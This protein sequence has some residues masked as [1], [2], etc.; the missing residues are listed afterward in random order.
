[1]RAVQIFAQLSSR[2]AGNMTAV[3]VCRFASVSGVGLCALELY[4]T[5]EG[6]QCRPIAR[7]ARILAYLPFTLA[8]SLCSLSAFLYRF[9]PALAALPAMQ[10]LVCGYFVLWNGS[11][12]LQSSERKSLSATLHGMMVFCSLTPTA[13]W[14]VSSYTMGRTFAELASPMG[15]IFSR[16]GGLAAGG[17][18][19]MLFSSYLAERLSPAVWAV[20]TD[21]SG[22]VGPEDICAAAKEYY[23]I[24]VPLGMATAMLQMGKGMLGSFHGDQTSPAPVFSPEEE[25]GK[26]AEQ[27]AS[28]STERRS[29]PPAPASS[30]T[31]QAPTSQSRQ[32][33]KKTSEQLIEIM[34]SDA[35]ITP[36]E[37]RECVLA[38]RA[39]RREM[40]GDGMGAV[41]Q[42]GKETDGGAEGFDGSP[43]PEG[44]EGLLQ[45]GMVGLNFMQ[46]MS[47]QNPSTVSR[48]PQRRSRGGPRVVRRGS[49]GSTSQTEQQ[50]PST[51]AR[52]AG[53]PGAST[54]PATKPTEEGLD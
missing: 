46:A 19:L 45:M 13:G 27:D 28:T 31:H 6:T 25:E 14:L 7:C 47:T 52:M 51:V 30:A 24:D 12:L 38:Y 35:D 3:N 20:M 48:G 16:L 33:T 42:E 2:L 21:M 54:Q 36:E 49:E 41:M 18:S 34:F 8:L 22:M 43:F 29:T 53:Q 10:Y 5:R 37:A 11:H 32:G 17:V 26:E 39:I 15:R 23:G 4:K 9:H 40:F 50:N 1:M 44:L